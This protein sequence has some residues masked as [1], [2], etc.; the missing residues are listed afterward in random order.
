LDNNQVKCW[1]VN[2]TG[3]RGAGLTRGTNKEIVGD[4]PGEMGDALPVV[5]LGTG[6]TAKS[7]SL[8]YEHTC[9]LLDNNQIKCWGYNDF[10]QLG[11]G[12]IA[13]RGDDN[14]EM[15]D[16][17]PTVSLGTGRSAKSV[18]AGEHAT[19]AVLDNNQLKCW[20]DNWRGEL[21]LGDYL[22]RGIAPNEMGDYLPYV[23]LGT[24]RTV[25]SVVIGANASLCAQLDNGLVKCWGVN[26]N[27]GTNIGLGWLGHGDAVDIGGVPGQMGDALPITSFGTDD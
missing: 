1:G 12:D 6:R 25:K 20:G 16:A 15:G 23:N 3:Q 7:I 4:E 8:G 17:L 18:S 26:S 21:G 14:G 10:G 2:W 5:N 27:Y 13:F 11:L 24:N 22:H 19:C 9:A